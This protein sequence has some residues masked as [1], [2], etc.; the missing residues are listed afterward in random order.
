MKT[1]DE[2]RKHFNKTYGIS[3][4]W[5]KTFEVSAE[6][7]GRVC[8]EIFEHN[9]NY[10]FDELTDDTLAIDVVLGPNKGIMFKNVELLIKKDD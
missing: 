10:D 5:P 9:L 2:L 8:Q 3:V 4:Q 6:L 7:Y 1:P